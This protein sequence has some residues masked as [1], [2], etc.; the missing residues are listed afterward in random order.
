[1]SGSRQSC[2]TES[3]KPD[4][5]LWGKLG[6]D[7]KPY[8]LLAHLLDSAASAQALLSHWIPSLLLARLNNRLGNSGH[9]AEQIVVGAAAL[10]DLGKLNPVFQGQLFGSSAK[11][12]SDQVAYL[13]K[14]GY[15]SPSGIRPPGNG[16]IERK[17]IT[18][19]EIISTVLL[20]NKLESDPTEFAC[21]VGG[22]HGK[23]QIFG[24]V[25]C[26]FDTYPVACSF[27]EA[28]RKDPR[29]NEQTSIHKSTVLEIIGVNPQIE[30]AR[31]ERAT[32]PLLT[33]LVCLADWIASSEKSIMDGLEK[34][35]L[36]EED[37]GSFLHQRQE[38]M[39][40]HVEEILG[41]PSKPEGNFTDAFGFEPNRP[42]Q[43]VLA[44][45]K[46]AP[47]L[48]VVMVPMGEG[49]TEAALGHW[50]LSAEEREGLYFALP[51]MATADAMFERIRRFFSSAPKPIWG[52]LA[53]S[54]S[55]LNSFYQPIQDEPV[56]LPTG[57]DTSDVGGLI[58]QDWFTGRH[59]ALLS[60]IT[61]GTIDQ[62]LAGV[63]R[64]RYNFLRLL[65]AATKTVILDEVHTYDPYMSEL[66]CGFLEWAGWLNI[67]VILLSATLPTRRLKEYTSAYLLGQGVKDT[68]NIATNYPSVIRVV[69][70]KCESIDLSNSASGREVS[71]KI[72][73]IA[74]GDASNT[75]ECIATLAREQAEKHPTAKIGIIMNTVAAAQ[76]VASQLR[77]WNTINLSVLHARMPAFE[78]GK[79]TETAIC[80][81][82]KES[83]DGAATLVATQVVEAS[84]DLDFDILITQ[85][86]PASSLIQRLG[87][88]WRHNRDNPS[89]QRCRPKELCGPLVFVVYPDPFPSN[90][91]AFLPYLPAEIKKTLDSF[92]KRTTVSIPSDVQCLINEADVSLSD[93]AEMGKAAE[94]AVIQ[95]RVKQLRSQE[96]RV[97]RPTELGQRISY[98]EKFTGGTLGNE[99]RATRLIDQ[100]TAIVLPI[101]TRHC[102]AW[103]NPLPNQPSQEE[104]LKLLSYTIPVNGTIAN[105]V[106][107]A[108]EQNNQAFRYGIFRHRLLSELVVVDIDATN[109]FIVDELLGL[110]EP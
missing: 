71:L 32:V 33:A 7:T 44:V 30:D 10:H 87:R 25:D 101:S 77:E 85:I 91:P 49:K 69:D 66:L 60:P 24:E 38:F 94:A 64:H 27:Y 5:H 84:I 103:T 47:G 9:S 106:W 17:F 19:H 99:E 20:R 107:Q 29:W 55:I 21:V 58:P 63:L 93:I 22:H 37:P 102:L 109:L 68:P 54:R 97:P 51:S 39:N 12:F 28:L 62:L 100:P 31:F 1:V 57:N 89:R 53:H 59:R 48:T 73:W 88:V 67:D 74:V 110:C 4:L 72:K 52:T 6:S 65:G 104:V 105:K 75:A 81:F 42:V 35:H 96:V 15:W 46:A 26:D 83:V 13:Q 98:L 16:D 45:Q 14:S 76:R 70:G 8:P 40:K 61:V 80:T 50:L 43:R 36:L 92:D 23:W 78:R 82:G 79:R 95:E 41:S 108:V 86:C 34:L 90:E 18:R 2:N 11:D 56:I 3:T